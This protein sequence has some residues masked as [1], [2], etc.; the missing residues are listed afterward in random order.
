MRPL[1]V[2]GDSGKQELYSLFREKPKRRSE[3]GTHSTIG[4]SVYQLLAVSTPRAS[5]SHYQGS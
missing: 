4:K 5:A 1:G 3:L 2:G